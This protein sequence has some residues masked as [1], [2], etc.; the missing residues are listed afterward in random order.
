MRHLIL[1]AALALA[2]SGCSTYPKS[3]YWLYNPNYDFVGNPIPGMNTIPTPAQQTE[4][5]IRADQA[6]HDD[7]LWRQRWAGQSPTE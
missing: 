6:R 4:A 5:A 3:L 7:A 2:L 1:T